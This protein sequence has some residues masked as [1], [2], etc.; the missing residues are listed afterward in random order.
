MVSLAQIDIL[1]VAYAVAFLT[2]LATYLLDRVK[3]RDRDLDPADVLAHPQRAGFVREHKGM[4]RAIVLLSAGGAAGIAIATEPLAA[5]LVPASLAGVLFYARPRDRSRWRPKDVLTLKN[6]S[7]ACSIIAFA[8]ALTLVYSH[9]RP[10]IEMLGAIWIPAIFL[11]QHV[12]ADAALCD[13][14]DRIA[15]ER[16]NTRTLAVHVGMARAKRVAVGIK[17]GALVWPV[18]S[19]LLGRLD[20]SVTI[21][22]VVLPAVFVFALSKWW[23][24]DYRDPIDLAL[25]VIAAIAYGASFFG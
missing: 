24:G 6:P 25:P 1:P 14:D 9:G 7:V 2:A 17:V 4:C 18:A 12:M 21:V 13:I 5:L 19:V 22:W 8:V 16:Y 10:M 15:D 3:L 11:A 23:G 20:A